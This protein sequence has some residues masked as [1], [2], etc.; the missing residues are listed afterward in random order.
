MASDSWEVVSVEEIKAPVENALST[1]P[2]GS[3]IGSRFFQD[4]GIP[5]IRGS[6][7]SQEIGFRLIDED[8]VYISREK[9]EEFKRSTVKEGDLIFTCWGTIT[10]VGL[11]DKRA[12][13]PSYVISNKQMK[14]TPDPAK[15]SS[16][17]LYYVFSS[18]QLQR[19]ISS[20]GIGSSVPGFNLGQLRSIRFSLPP[21]AE[22]RRIAHILGSLDDKIALNRQLN[23]TLEQL[24]RTLF[25]SWFVDFDPVRAKASGEPKESICR[26]LGLTPELLAL[27]PAALE[28][29]A[30][31]EIPVGWEVKPF[32][33]LAKFVNKSVKPYEKL[34]KVWEHFSLPAFD[35]NQQPT[36]D[37]G[38]SIKSNKFLVPAN[39]VLISK[40]NPRIPRIWRP[41][42]Q[43]RDAIASTEFM[44]FVGSNK[45]EQSLI[46]CLITSEKFQTDLLQ[47][48]KGSTGSHQRVG[49]ADVLKIPIVLAG[50]DVQTAFSSLVESFLDKQTQALTESRTLA[51]L[52]DELLPKLLSG[53]IRL[54]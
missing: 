44:P 48:V 46:Y 47:R 53:E 41:N 13:Y 54:N 2:F 30:M 35:A 52:R 17:F 6:N 18:P 26:R 32:S 5:V 43:S 25:Q 45:R 12:K 29:S 34:E 16:L 37:L 33:V 3:S 51:A 14:F 27:F 39:A 42:P 19:I 31:G 23:A 4:T 15:A 40:L 9:A 28:D 50:K 49:P 22:Q 1:G 11:I 24:A 20:Q 10:Q 7:L 21:L 8:I 36:L 38:G